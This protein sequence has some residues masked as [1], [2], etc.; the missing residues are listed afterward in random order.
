MDSSRWSGSLA[1]EE[2]EARM[3][4]TFGMLRPMGTFTRGMR[5]PGPAPG[6]EAE[7]PVPALEERARPESAASQHSEGGGVAAQRGRR[8]RV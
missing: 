2:G 4:A 7:G 5:T 3:R 1:A 6:A 8:Q